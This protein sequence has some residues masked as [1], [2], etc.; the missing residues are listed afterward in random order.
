MKSF[1]DAFAPYAKAVIAFIAPGVLL[2]GGGPLADGR[3]PTTSE[4]L[5]ALGIS[6]VT[7]FAVFTMPNKEI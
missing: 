2:I 5:M 3:V 7:A 1:I 4:W 6:L